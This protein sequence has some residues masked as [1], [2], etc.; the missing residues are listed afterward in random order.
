[1]ESKKKKLVSIT[2]NKFRKQTREERGAGEGHDQGKGLRG[3]NYHV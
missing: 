2:R 3:T 1:M